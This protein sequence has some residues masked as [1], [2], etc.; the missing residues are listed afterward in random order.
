MRGNFL[1]LIFRKIPQELAPLHKCRLPGFTGPDPSTTLDKADI[2]LRLSKSTFIILHR[3]SFVNTFFLQSQYFF[4]T[5]ICEYHF[6]VSQGELVKV[7]K[8]FCDD[9]K[10]LLHRHM[11]TVGA[12]HIRAQH[13]NEALLYQLHAP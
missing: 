6:A 13:M 5:F 8:L 11:V 2:L 4:Y 7:I 1:L 12:V 3:Y 10:A 9:L